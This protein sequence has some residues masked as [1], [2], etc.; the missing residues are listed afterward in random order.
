MP[1]QPKYT[2]IA[3]KNL[4][5]D[6]EERRADYRSFAQFLRHNGHNKASVY[7]ALERHNVQPP[8]LEPD[9]RTH[10]SVQRQ[11]G[12]PPEVYAYRNELPLRSFKKA[13]ENARTPLRC[14]SH[15]A[16]KQWWRAMFETFEPAH[17]SRWLMAN[18]LPLHLTAKAYGRFYRPSRYDLWGHAAL[19]EIDPEAV[20]RLR[21]PHDLGHPDN[22]LFYLT[23]PDGY[24][25]ALTAPAAKALQRPL[26]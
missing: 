2:V 5:D 25:R 9:W 20:D 18:D 6:F 12:C 8:S 24:W 26:D 1:P 13:V 11:Q 23:G 19:I 4:L 7:R 17:V 21:E 16:K 14:T 3:L 10:L 22:A 15:E